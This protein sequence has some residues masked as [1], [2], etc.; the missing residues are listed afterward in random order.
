MPYFNV[1]V[2]FGNKGKITDKGG[3]ILIF[4][5]T[6]YYKWILPYMPQICKDRNTGQFPIQFTIKA[7]LFELFRQFYQLVAYIKTYSAS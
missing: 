7:Q 6:D 3:A 1:F 2:F 5:T 4:S